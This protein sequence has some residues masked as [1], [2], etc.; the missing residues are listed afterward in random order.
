MHFIPSLLSQT[1]IKHYISTV[2][3]GNMSFAF[4]EKE[5]VIENRKK[6]LS[7]IKIPSERFVFLKAQHGTKIIE[8]TPSLAGT[9]IF[10][11]ETAIKADALVTREKHLALLLLTADCIPAI[12]YNREKEIIGLSHI[13]RHNTR[14][15]FSQ[16]LVS[17]LK[18]DYGIAPSSLKFYF[19]PSIK[20]ESYILPQYPHGFDLIEENVNQ[21][22]FKG[23]IQDNIHVDISDTASLPN[24]FSHYRAVRKHESEGRVAT[25]LM[26]V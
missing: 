16:I 19:G 15:G 1:K 9:G 2:E 12:F 8:A 7:K 10:S 6:F 3:N 17:L 4:G 20:K 18:R 11:A 14:Q 26:Q 22:V 25:I 23:V 13:S 5:S 24:F 21:L